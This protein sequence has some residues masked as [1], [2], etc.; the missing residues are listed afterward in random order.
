M[1]IRLFISAL[2]SLFVIVDPFGTSAVYATL[3]Q[4]MSGAE[5]R[6]VALRGTTIATVLLVLFSVGGEAVLRYLHVSLP[7]FRVAGGLLLFVTAFRMLMGF[8]DPDRLNSKNTV[9]RDTSD[10]AI[11]PIAIPLLAGPGVM[12]ATL[13]FATEARS[14]P[15]HAMVIIAIVLIQIT[16]FLSMRGAAILSRIFGPTGKGIIARVMG[17]LLAALAVQFIADGIKALKG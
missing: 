11:F 8:H 16:A 5:Q 3:T 1:E 9:Y 15:G 10:I 2:V 4:H 14:L 13:M 6:R 7:A 17:I 12:T